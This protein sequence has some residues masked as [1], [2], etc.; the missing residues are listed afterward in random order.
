MNQSLN[1]A[2]YRMACAAGGIGVWTWDVASGAVIY[3][4]VARQIIGLPPDGVSTREE[5]EGLIHPQDLQRFKESL[6]RALDPSGSGTLLLEQRMLRPETGGEFWI[7]AKG[8]VSF[9]GSVPI[10]CVGILRDV[11]ERRRSE[12]RFAGIVSIA[13]DAIIS[14]NEQ[15]R[16]TLFNDGA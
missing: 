14:I 8:K 7:T 12:A 15:Q 2:H 13:A 10:Q 4:A 1:D 6:S 5:F 3:D 9:S 16:I 11:T